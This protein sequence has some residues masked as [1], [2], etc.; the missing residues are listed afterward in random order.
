[1]NVRSVGQLRAALKKSELSPEA[2]APELKVSNMTIRRWLDKSDSMAIP[3]KYHPHLDRL[4]G[5]QAIAAKAARPLP[6]CTEFSPLIRELEASG[7]DFNGLS[8]LKVDLKKK[9]SG[10]SIGQGLRSLVEPVL[11]GAIAKKTSV[12]SRAIMVGALLYF[13]NPFDLIPDATPV[14]GFLD[15]LAVLS[16]AAGIAAKESSKSNKARTE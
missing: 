12:R 10:V 1:M 8:K 11:K 15:D 16:L 13:L 6:L 4:F 7:K 3:E 9:L 2:A 14:V 5:S